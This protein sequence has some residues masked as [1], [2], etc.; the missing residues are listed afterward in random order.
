M[1]LCGEQQ[2]G[3]GLFLL[4]PL[5]FCDKNLNACWSIACDSRIISSITGL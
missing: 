4:L 2:E 1:G 3:G 5:L